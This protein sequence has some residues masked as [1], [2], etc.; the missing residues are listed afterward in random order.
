MPRSS[1]SSF[2]ELTPDLGTDEIVKRLKI[3]CKSLGDYESM[4]DVNSSELLSLSKCLVQT[5]LQSHRSREVRG[6]VSCCIADIF[7]LCY[8]DPP[9]DERERKVVFDNF[10]R[11][12]QGL[13]KPS[14]PAFKYSFQLLETLA[15]IRLFNVC[16]EMED[17]DTFTDIFR[18]LFSVI[19]QEQSTKVKNYIVDILSA[20]VQDGD[21]LPQEVIDI[22]LTNILEP[23]KSDNKAAYTFTCEFIRK[24][25]SHIEPYIQIFFNNALMVGKSAE[26]TV[27]DHLYDLVLELH[28]IDSSVLLAVLPQLEF[29]L[30]STDNEERFEVTQLLAKMFSPKASKLSMENRPL[31]NCFLG[32]FADVSPRIRV[33]CIK[34]SKY[35]LLYHPHLVEAVA[36]VLHDRFY[37]KEERVRMEVIKAMC[38]VASENFEAVPKILGEDL[39]GRMRD[40]VWSIRKEC[41]NSLAR[42]YRQFMSSSFS[43]GG[44]LNSS[45]VKKLQW[46]PTKIM[47]AYY[48]DSVEDKMCVERCFLSC[49]VPVALSDSQRMERML[50]VYNSLNDEHAVR[51]FDAL[52]G[53]RHR[54]RGYLLE[55]IET[56]QDD[57][58]LQGDQKKQAILTQVT[59]L[60]RHLPDSL[61]SQASLDYLVRLLEE[62]KLRESLLKAIDTS[63]TCS[64]VIKAKVDVVERVGSKA[65]VLDTVRSILDRACP[66]LIDAKCIEILVT[67]VCDEVCSDQ[68]Q[69]QEEEEGQ[70]Q[71]KKSLQLIRNLAGIMPTNFRSSMVFEK[72]ATLLQHEDREIVKCALQILTLTGE[73]VDKSTTGVL[74]PIL[75]DLAQRGH[76][77]LSKDALKC[78][79]QVFEDP[80][81]AFKRLYSSLI[82]HLDYKDEN[83]C[84]VLISLGQVAK[85]QPQVFASSYKLVI[86][87]FVVKK[88]IAVDR[89][90]NEFVEGDKEWGDDNLISYETK[91]KVLGMKLLVNWLLGLSTMPPGRPEFE[92]NCK[93]VLQL[94]DTT[95]THNG[96]LQDVDNIAACDR[97]RL[98]LAASCG[99]IKLAKCSMVRDFITVLMFQ[100]LAFTVQDTCEEVRSRFMEKLNK[101]L[102]SLRLPLGYLAFMVFVGTEPNKPLLNRFQKMITM[103]VTKRRQVMN[104]NFKAMDNRHAIMPEYAV[105]HAVYLVA[106]HTSYSRTD[107]Q[108][109]DKFKKC[110]WFFLEP[111]VL[112]G[113]SYGFLVKLLESIKVTVDAQHPSNAENTKNLYSA[114]DLAMGVMEKKL[115]HLKLGDF[116]GDLVLP[117]KLYQAKGEGQQQPNTVRYLPPDYNCT[118][119]KRMRLEQSPADEAE[120]AP[121]KPKA[122]AAGAKAS[123]SVSR[124]VGGA[125]KQKQKQKVTTAPTKRKQASTAAA[126]GKK[127]TTRSSARKA[128]K[129]R[130]NVPSSP[131]EPEEEEKEK[132]PEEEENAAKSDM[133]EQAEVAESWPRRTRSKGAPSPADNVPG[134]EEEEQAE[135]KKK[136]ARKTTRSKTAPTP[137]NDSPEGAAEVE[138][139]R[140]RRNTRSRAA[141]SK[142]GNSSPEGAGCEVPTGNKEDKEES[143]GAVSE[144][145]QAAS[146][147]R[148]KMDEAVATEPP[149]IKRKARRRR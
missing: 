106:H 112:R 91:V 39:E 24:T 102:L 80:K 82:P 124:K 44:T 117:H 5:F 10:V 4:D 104:Q 85:L 118:P 13:E 69:E 139:S 29:K 96:D 8:P 68:E 30:K 3:C 123:V 61:K 77:E 148:P 121:T 135:P 89:T 98:R 122:K 50:H 72:L 137:A 46:I 11:Q 99:F 40:K 110:L 94:L 147:K 67:K 2:Q 57:S 141:A 1:T 138:V 95:L 93:A 115:K 34:Y 108:H 51:A 146:E 113:E 74:E 145:E 20:L 16:L 35:F 58:K 48:R 36:S 52:L 87:D 105:S 130:A 75:M 127:K 84:T 56:Q 41:I 37:D 143:D 101:G 142:P 116:S 23:S 28:A 62:E 18:M 111:M 114:C 128:A 120:T 119:T 66:M 78:M 132:E 97:S 9:Y 43:S 100:T 103:N 134:L 19:N 125:Q 90:K 63:C 31:W 83:L 33:E 22:I 107:T 133:E 6:L 70:K 49:I 149:K 59:R 81:P 54:I 129:T 65:S 60:T 53:S 86:K 14:S 71:A 26:S 27:V 109:L 17:H 140:G 131:E 144:V 15:R 25:S 42:L 32:R 7:R 64:E 88:L 136:R 126:A 92:K 38:E 47:H 76:P 73:H 12:L 21:F 45:S 55:L 79:K